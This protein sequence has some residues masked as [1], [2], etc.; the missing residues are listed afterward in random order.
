MRYI[1][2]ILTLAACEPVD[3]DPSLS[4]R[5]EPEAPEPEPDEPEDETPP[6]PTGF[7]LPR[8]VDTQYTDCVSTTYTR[9]GILRTDCRAWGSPTPEAEAFYLEWMQAY[10]EDQGLVADVDFEVT[11]TS[12]AGIR[13][14]TVFILTS[15]PY[16]G[17]L[18]KTYWY[19]QVA[20]LD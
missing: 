11:I 19:D 13:S 15:L 8:R 2:L 6:E 20:P 14:A 16:L 18:N 10:L 1:L 12:S 7:Y 9:Q 4:S 5:A 17:V 3:I